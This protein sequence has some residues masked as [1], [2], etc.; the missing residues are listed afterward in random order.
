MEALLEMAEK[1]KD[2]DLKTQI[3]SFLKDPKLSIQLYGDE[4][5]IEEAPASKGYHHSYPGGLLEHTI[6]MTNIA[7]GIAEILQ[8]VYQIDFINKDLLIAGG[9]LH[10]LFKPYTYTKHGEKYERSRIGSKID[11]T[12]L[13][14]GEIW[15]RKFPIEL[16]HIIL[17][18]HGKGAPAQP[19]SLEA[20]ILHLA[21]YVDSNL[22]GDILMGAYKILERA[23]IKRKMDNSKYAAKICDLMA[24]E[25]IEGVKNYVKNRS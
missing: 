10:D 3:L 15:K 17:A 20:L 4:I 13:M 19:R 5:T 21:D 9:I 11:H 22:L 12:S 8:K 1:I 25:G 24:K 2:N 18:H 16:I 23:G 6:A 14:F 7:L